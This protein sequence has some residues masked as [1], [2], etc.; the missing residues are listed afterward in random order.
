MKIA[1][2]GKKDNNHQIP[3]NHQVQEED[4]VDMENVKE[5][6]RSYGGRICVSG[7]EEEDEEQVTNLTEYKHAVT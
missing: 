7:V 3:N 2:P 5:T 4:R 6:D 1:Q